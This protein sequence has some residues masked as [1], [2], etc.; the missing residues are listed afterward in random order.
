MTNAWLLYEKIHSKNIPMLAFMRDI[1]DPMLALS[2]RKK[3]PS[4]QYTQQVLENL[5]T[6]KF[7][8]VMINGQSKY[9]HGKVCKRR[10]VFI[11]HKV[12]RFCIFQPVIALL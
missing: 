4:L 2:R 7:D 10:L 8:H 12:Q 11:C 5:R 6:D 1:V 3:L 9:R